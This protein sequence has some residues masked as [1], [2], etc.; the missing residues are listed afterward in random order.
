MDE[1]YFDAASKAVID[2]YRSRRALSDKQLERLPLF[3]LAR[4][5]TYA[6]W[7]HTRPETQ[8]ARELTGMLVDMCCRLARDY[9]GA[10][11]R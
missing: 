9:L 8:T 7:V 3:F 1:P 11:G 5:L 10:S 6:G 2:G 4:G